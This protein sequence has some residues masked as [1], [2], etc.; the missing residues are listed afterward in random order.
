[1]NKAYKQLTI[2]ALMALTYPLS[3]ANA[4]GN[5]PGQPLQSTERINEELAMLEAINQMRMD[6]SRYRLHVEAAF[7][8]MLKDSVALKNEISE[9]V[10]TTWTMYESG[11]VVER[12]TVRRDRFS[13]LKNAYLDLLVDLANAPGLQPLIPSSELYGIATEHARTSA[14]DGYLEHQ[15]KD[16]SLPSDRI[17]IAMPWTQEG[18]ENI[19]AGPG[20]ANAIL[21]QLMVDS[22]VDSRGHRKNLMN[23]EWRYVACHKVSA[24]STTELTW[25]VQEFAR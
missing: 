19:A 2:S 13:Q 23:P 25:W 6:P 5:I 8:M 1:M 7:D 20:D 10:T 15:G 11:M 14:S 24:I 22:G 16:G 4:S 21:L 12:D 18:N 9:T 3:N 17:S